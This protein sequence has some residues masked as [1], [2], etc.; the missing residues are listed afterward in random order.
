MAQ[1]VLQDEWKRYSKTQQLKTKTKPQSQQCIS[2]ACWKWLHPGK[3]SSFILISDYILISDEDSPGRTLPGYFQASS[4][5][6]PY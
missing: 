3:P 5:E 2:R 6:P 1:P 4:S